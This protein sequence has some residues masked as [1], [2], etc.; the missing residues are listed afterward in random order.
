MPD[1]LAD[2]KVIFSISSILK[3][4]FFFSDLCLEVAFDLND[5][6]KVPIFV[7]GK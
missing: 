1:H 5:L 6:H 2:L 4:I 7:L 3:V